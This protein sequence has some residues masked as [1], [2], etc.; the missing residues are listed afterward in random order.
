MEW[1]GMLGCSGQL[2]QAGYAVERVWWEISPNGYLSLIITTLATAGGIRER[3]QEPSVAHIETKIFGFW[4]DIFRS[5]P[6][7][8]LSV[9]CVPTFV[10]VESVQLP[11]HPAAS[12]NFWAWVHLSALCFFKYSQNKQ[13]TEINIRETVLFVF[14]QTCSN[15]EGFS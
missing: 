11:K 10:Q 3:K 4:S 13:A 14:C 15:T 8:F 6:S 2:G 9:I 1:A 5:C 12:P 7:R